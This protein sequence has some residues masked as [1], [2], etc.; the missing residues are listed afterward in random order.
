MTGK[1]EEE[2]EATQ[3][4]AKMSAKR[5]VAPPPVPPPAAPLPQGWTAHIMDGQVFYVDASGHA[6]WDRPAPARAPDSVGAGAAARA[7]PGAGSDDDSPQQKQ[8][9]PPPT[10]DPDD[11]EAWYAFNQVRL[12]L[13]CGLLLV[14]GARDRLRFTWK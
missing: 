12:Q 2:S 14:C 4:G 13:V 5:V 3:M 6:Q 7:A 9:P 10:P 1:R 8:P 11:K